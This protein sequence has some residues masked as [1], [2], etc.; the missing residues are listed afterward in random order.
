M[1][2]E[3]S[4]RPSGRAPVRAI[5]VTP[6]VMSVPELVIHFFSPLMT[7]APSRSSAVV[8]VPPASVPAFG[9]V[10]PKA[11][12]RRP[13]AQGA[14]KRSYCSGVPQAASGAQ[15]SEM[16]ASIVIPTEVSARLI[17]SN[18]RL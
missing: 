16:C 10:R 9:S 6:A 18:A 1:I 12:S 4:G 14:R 8:S 7:Q 3:S 2:A 11:Q 5:T 17:S 15:P 13:V